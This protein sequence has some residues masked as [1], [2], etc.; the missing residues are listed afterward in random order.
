LLKKEDDFYI[1]VICYVPKKIK[2]I[3]EKSIGIDLGI[4]TTVTLSN[5]EKFDINIPETKQ[6]KLQQRSLSK[7]YEMAKKLANGK[8]WVRSNNYK[9][10][11][12][13]LAKQYQKV[14]N[15]RKEARI[16]LVNSIVK[17]FKVVCFQ[18]ENVKG[19][20][21]SL[22]GKKTQNSG[23]GGIIADLRRRSHT[24]VEIA[25][26]F[27]S[28]GLCPVCGLKT[29]HALK[30]RI[31]VCPNCGYTKDRDIHGANNNLTEGLRL[32]KKKEIP[33]D[34][35]DS[36]LAEIVSSGTTM[37]NGCERFGLAGSSKLLSLKQEAR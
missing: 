15:R 11:Q 1:K 20:C 28:T 18:D 13:R 29:P 14:V 8:C 12:V 21:S 10:N 4:L 19:W 35:R 3:P 33:T 17:R 27:P 26:N 30:D 36:K 5:G 23:L 34:H 24:P 2:I 7:K 37:N 22:F 31:F 25:S 6:L 9:K 32:L 16:K